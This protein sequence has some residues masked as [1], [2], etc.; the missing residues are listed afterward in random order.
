MDTLVVCVDRAGDIPRTAGIDAPIAGWEAVQS[1]V[2]DVGVADPEDSGVNAMLEALHVTRDLRDTDEDATVAVVSGRSDSVVGA[3]RA[4]AAQVDDL[5]ERYDPDSVV[6][7]VDSA[8]DERLVPIIESRVPVD[9]VD[10]VVVRQA[11]DIEST[12]YLLKQ[13]LADEELRQTVLVPFGVVLLVFP[14]LMVIT[15]SLALAAAAITAV[16]GL[17][18]VYKGLGVDEYLATL[19]AA[20]RDALYSGRVSIV[21]YVVAAGLA[22][23]GVFV[24]VLGV[25]RLPGDVGAVILAVAFAFEGVPWMALAALAASA[26]RLVDEAI[27]NDRLR[28]AYLNLPFGVVAVGLVVRGFSAYILE[29]AGHLGA[30]T[31]PR[32]DVGLIT[33][34]RVELTPEQRL[35]MFVL[36]GVVV[37]VVGIRVASS[38]SREV[39]PERQPIE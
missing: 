22:A 3:D 16:L 13:F 4:V 34:N 33:V 24:G 38:L 26:G 23:I 28:P 9:A 18:L 19:P 21:T 30:F 15:G 8:E 29:R 35:A 12:Y 1:L 25:S 32:I 2:L 14:A 7:V 17:F 6:V 37:S 39:E 20:T 10:R 11:R 31:V 27:Q 5:I 36:V